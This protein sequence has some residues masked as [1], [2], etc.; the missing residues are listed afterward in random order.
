METKA[1]HN[2]IIFNTRDE[3]IKVD[4]RHVAYFH[5]DRN[6]TEVFLTNGTNL[7]LTT[8]M[9]NIEKILT[10]LQAKSKVMSFVRIGRSYIINLKHVLQV[11][12]LRQRLVLCD[13][14]HSTVYNLDVSKEALKQLKELYTSR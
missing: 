9:S 14:K 11:D 10:G 7:L 5:A 6:Y 1:Q 13:P 2:L 12:V 3:L 4:L 8:S